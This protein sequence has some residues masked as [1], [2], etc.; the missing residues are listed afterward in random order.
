[1]QLSTL[2]ENLYYGELNNLIMDSVTPG[3]LPTSLAK[4]VV[5]Y[6]N[7]SLTAIYSRLSLLEKE[8]II[9]AQDEIFI[10]Y[11][12]KKYAVQDST[13][14]PANMKYIRDT[15]DDPFTEDVLRIIAVYDELGTQLSL[16]EPGDAA[17][18]YTPKF[19]AIQIP[20]PVTGNTY[21]VLYQANHPKVDGKLMAA[22]IMLPAYLEIGLRAHIAGLLFGSMNGQEHVARALDHMATYETVMG[23]A[24]GKDL[25]RTS[26][27]IT[28]TKLEDR[29]F[30]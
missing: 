11:L 16:N 3:V 27:P 22:E 17:S 30:V 20:T 15:E 6:L 9:E 1:M 4:K 19:N 2:Y 28:I 26:L 23:Q 5:S 7:Q 10:Y 13:V 14:M 29:G 21:T 24:E 12:Q 18:L 25:A 8:V